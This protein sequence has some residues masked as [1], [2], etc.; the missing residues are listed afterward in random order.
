MKRT[1]LVAP[2]LLVVACGGTNATVEEL[3][4]A[5]PQH[6]WFGMSLAAVR[7]PAQTMCAASGASTY[8]SMTHQVAASVDGVIADVLAEVAAI[9]AQPP[10]ASQ[11]GQAAWGPIVGASS[12][13]RL[14]AA[15]TDASQ[16]Q[17]ELAGEPPGAGEAGWRV[18]LGGAT[19]VADQ[20]H[21]MGYL[22][23]DFGVMN[24]LDP[25]V[26][27]SAGVVNAGFSIDGGERDVSARFMGIV[28]KSAPQPDDSAYAF[29]LAPD[30]SA[31]FAFQTHVDYD[32]NG[33]LDELVHIDSRWAADGSGT[34]H[35][36]VSGGGLGQ[37]TVSAVECW[38]PAL[39]RVYYQADDIN[40]T[41]GDPTCC[42]F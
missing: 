12:I 24:A 33:M 40:A 11:P 38:D 36:T 14:T 34:A 41:A 26:D 20:Q 42:P 39:G 32:H 21:R 31:G 28:G 3:R 15:Q 25:T 6:A 27:P 5:A 9:T 35:I 8:G 1:I 29:Q 23:I 22:A 7:P 37:S 18:V 16:Y 19:V 13:Y 10:A 17:F 30:Q 2:C 4:A